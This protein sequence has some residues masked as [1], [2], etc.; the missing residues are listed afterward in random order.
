MKRIFIVLTVFFL[1]AM[2]SIATLNLPVFGKQPSGERLERI[3][4]SP[5]YRDGAFQNLSFTPA[6]AEDA[7]FFGVVTEFIFGKSKRSR[8]TGTIPSTKIN[9][10]ELNRGED[11]LV[12]FGHSSYFMQIGGVRMLVDPVFSGN[13]SPFSFAAKAFIGTERYTAGDIPEIDILL[14]T[15]DHYDHLDYK[16]VTALRPKIKKVVTGLGTGEHLE[17][18]GYPGNIITELDW[19]ESLAM[20]HGLVLHSTPARHFSGR[21]FK[22][23]QAL[24]TSF[25]LQ[26]PGMQIFIGGDSGYD[27]H[28]AEIGR[29]YGPFDLAILENGQYNKGWKYIHMMPDELLRAATELNV[30]RLMPVHSGKFV[31]ANHAWDEP[32]RL[33][34]ENNKAVGMG[35]VTPIIGEA[36]QLS[37]TLRVF[38]AWWE[39]VN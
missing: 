8:P 11:V 20:D 35:L 25:V 28:F 39:G 37:D 2:A 15:H 22:R 14:I 3:K 4:L 29:K 10:H 13:A 6:L 5:N 23:N 24:W 27:T 34:V 21:L 18:W 16:T 12:W 1:I 30:K 19:Y 32:L 9:L 26:T 17:H 38:D 7:N 31:L 36:V 33:L